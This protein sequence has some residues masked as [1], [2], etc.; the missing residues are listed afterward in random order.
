MNTELIDGE[1]FARM[2][3]GGAAV[4]SAHASELNAMNVFPVSDGDTGTNMTKTMEGGLSSVGSGTVCAKS[5]ITA[6][7][8][9]RV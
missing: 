7:C 2:L 9:G 8:P 3:S 1:L 6:T 5:T 4:L